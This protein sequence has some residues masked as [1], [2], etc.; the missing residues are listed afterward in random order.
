M[1][2]SVAGVFDSVGGMFD[3]VA[4]V[5]DSVAGAGD[6][7]EVSMSSCSSIFAWMFSL[8]FSKEFSSL[9][10]FCSY[11]CVNCSIT[12]WNMPLSFCCSTP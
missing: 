2:D 8:V 11:S 3:S 9:A 4:G 10:R 5:F 12:F 7:V 1:L 6:G